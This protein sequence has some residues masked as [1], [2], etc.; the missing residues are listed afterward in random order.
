MDEQIARYIERAEAKYCCKYRGM[1]AD[2]NDPLQLGR[3]KLRVPSIL[4]DAVTGWAWPAS[5]YA[6]KGIGFLF[7]P[8][9]DDLVWVEFVEGDLE[10]PIWSGCSGS[11]ISQPLMRTFC[12]SRAISPMRRMVHSG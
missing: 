4:A 1:V 12:R 10:H 9:V 8:Q 2:R 7:I 6:G 11:I 5:P 3:L